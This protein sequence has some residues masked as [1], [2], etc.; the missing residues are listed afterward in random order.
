MII[1][2]LIIMRAAA[3]ARAAAPTQSTAHLRLRHSGLTISHQH[4]D[5]GAA[6]TSR[7]VA[8]NGKHIWPLLHDIAIFNMLYGRNKPRNRVFQLS[9]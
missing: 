5:Q 1:T 6:S 4:Q 8:K 7:P 2:I 9:L 3:G